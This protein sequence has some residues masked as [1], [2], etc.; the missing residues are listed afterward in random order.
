M[1]MQFNMLDNNA[2]PLDR[3]IKEKIC[4]CRPQ[5]VAEI[6]DTRACIRNEQ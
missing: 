3:H 1:Y 5:D 2:E 6:R 4:E